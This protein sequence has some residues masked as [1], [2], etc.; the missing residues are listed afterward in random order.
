MTTTCFNNGNFPSQCSS[1]NCSRKN[2]LGWVTVH[3]FHVSHSCLPW[4]INQQCSRTKWNSSD[5]IMI[6]WSTFLSPHIVYRWD[7]KFTVYGWDTKFT[8]FLFGHGFLHRDFTDLHGI[9]HDVKTISQSGLMKFWGRYPQ[10][11]QIVA[12]NMTPGDFLGAPYGGICVLLMHSLILASFYTFG[13]HK[14][15]HFKSGRRF[16][17][18]KCKPTDNK[19]PK[20]QHDQLCDAGATWTYHTLLCGALSSRRKIL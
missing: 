7:S 11:W 18:S 2:L 13:T 10:G 8:V 3:Q 1:S 20:R 6:T 4:P 14:A 12:L 19:L 15:R 5:V 9:W 17:C 16:D